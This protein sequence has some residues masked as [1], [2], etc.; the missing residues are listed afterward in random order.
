VKSVEKE[1]ERR[2][3]DICPLTHN[4]EQVFPQSLTEASISEVTS[5]VFDILKSKPVR[6]SSGRVG[7]D[8]HS[9]LS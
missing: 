3:F 5:I 6:L 8:L 2:T 4:Q 7:I 1:R 9:G